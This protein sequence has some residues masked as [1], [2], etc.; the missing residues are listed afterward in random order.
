MRDDAA[1]RYVGPGFTGTLQP[2]QFPIVRGGKIVGVGGTPTPPAE[3]DPSAD[4]PVLVT[5]ARDD[6][7]QTPNEG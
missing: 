3:E 5:A 1:R 7:R 4:S 2:G 6:C